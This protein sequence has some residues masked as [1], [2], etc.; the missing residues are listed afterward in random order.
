M[1]HIFSADHFLVAY[2]DVLGQSNKILENSTYP[3]TKKEFKKIKDNLSETSEYVISL[4]EAFRKH[5]KKYRKLKGALDGL[6]EKQKQNEQIM[7]T[8]SAELRGVS[9]AVIITVPL[10][11]K[12]DNCIPVNNI[13]ATLQGIC[14]IYN[15][16]LAQH[17]PIRGGIDVGWGTRLAQDEVYGSALVKAYTLETEKA[18]YPRIIIGESLWKYINYVENFKPTTKYGTRAKIL[19]KRCKDLIVKDSDKMY[20][21]D[22][23]GKAVKS[24]GTNVSCELVKE[25]YDYVSKFQ[26][27]CL[28]RGDNKLGSRY[29]LLKNYFESR[30]NVWGLKSSPS[31]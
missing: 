23:I 12:T 8:F 19:A 2:I 11:N 17:K 13:L 27:T 15:I 24:S 20:I 18:K 6:S 10:E 4:R 1:K 28:Q 3:P 30:L 26:L 22:V 9:D 31:R 29:Q 14:L 16:A 7:Q 21:L 25:A 5:F